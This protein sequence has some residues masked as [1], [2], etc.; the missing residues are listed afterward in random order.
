MFPAAWQDR[1][2]NPIIVGWLFGYSRVDDLNSGVA[3][4]DGVGSHLI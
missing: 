2:A 4:P 3:E 1:Q